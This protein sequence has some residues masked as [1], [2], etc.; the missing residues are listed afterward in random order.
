M[1]K[2]QDTFSYQVLL[3]DCWCPFLF[4][5]RGYMRKTWEHRRPIIKFKVNPRRKNK[6]K[7][8]E[9]ITRSEY[10]KELFKIGAGWNE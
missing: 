5:R 6:A 10:V 2:I 8:S 9:P 7:Q 1:K 3:D 4:I